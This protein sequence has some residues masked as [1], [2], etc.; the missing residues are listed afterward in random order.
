MFPKQKL[1]EDGWVVITTG[2]FT[3]TVGVPDRSAAIEEQVPL[4]SVAIEYVVVTTGLTLTVMVGATPVKGVP[5]ES[6]PE[7][8]PAPVTAKLK[9]AEFP[10]QIVVAPLK[11]PVGL[12]RIVIVA[13][14]VR[15]P[16][17]D[18]Q[19]ASLKAVMV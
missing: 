3:V 2:L 4:V 5:S 9:V 13:L 18:V 6:V 17:T 8:V 10:L 14:P 7:I 11:A 1:V 12:G 15:S 19:I 16:A